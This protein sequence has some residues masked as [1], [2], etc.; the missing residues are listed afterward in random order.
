MKQQH[1]KALERLVAILPDP[2]LAKRFSTRQTGICL[3]A[4]LDAKPRAGLLAGKGT[5]AE[6]ARIHDILEFA[7]E[8]LGIRVAENTRETYRKTSL[9]PLNEVGVINRHQLS[10]NDPNTFY[11]ISAALVEPLR[12][13]VAGKGS[14]RALQ[15]FRQ[16]AAKRPS[17]DEEQPVEV[18]VSPANTFLLSAGAHSQLA[19]VFVETFGPAFLTGP[20][21]VYIGDTARKSG[22]QNRGLMRELNLPVEVKAGLPDVVLFSEAQ[23]RLIVCE[24]VTSTG[25]V[26]S[27]RLEQLRR[28]V[29]GPMKLGHTVEFVT[30]FPSRAVLR[31]FVEQ[32]AWG[33]SV[34][35]AAEP[36][37]LILFQE[38]GG[39]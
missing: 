35:I 39:Q 7:R 32:I 12:A 4:L 28:L 8:E 29:H 27:S 36:N 17:P 15:E 19:K 18:R 14:D 38:R 16:Q 5:L 33:T 20:Q 22:Y 6:G 26:T 9:R 10:T 31:R 11:R 23:R 3:H 2:G 24:V 34:W 1:R 13:V 37:N 30:A 21:V 25:P